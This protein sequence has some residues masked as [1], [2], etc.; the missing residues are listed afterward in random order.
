MDGPGS[1]PRFR[2]APEGWP[3]VVGGAVVTL[4]LAGVG[5]ALA[6]VPGGE[7]G[8]PGW[9]VAWGAA[10]V[11][12][13]LTALAAYFFRDPPRHPPPAQDLVVAPADGRI[14][15][16][17][18]VEEVPFLGGPSVRIATFLSI[19]DVHVQRAPL[20]GTVLHRSYRAGKFLAAWNPR[21]AVDNEQAE[22]G[23]ARGGEARVLVRQIA[24][25]AARRIVT[26]PRPGDE[27]ER[28]MRIGLIRFGSRVDL[29]VPAHW[30]ILCR[31]GDRVR[32]GET[33]VARIV[34][35]QKDEPQP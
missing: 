8:S 13:L 20:S 18:Q 5:S 21:A 2:L 11:A 7:V 14:L 34:G 28:G 12:G 9:A 35:E 32:A 4:A 23:I 30:E 6:L 24:G 27:V 16:V 29:F 1:R 3:F 22:L 25:V 19:F 33:A 26:D 17:A 15:E 31:A 10:G